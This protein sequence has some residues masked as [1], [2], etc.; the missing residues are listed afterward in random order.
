[1]LS[2]PTWNYFTG[3]SDNSGFPI[4]FLSIDW[5]IIFVEI[6]SKWNN[7]KVKDIAIFNTI[8]VII[9]LKVLFLKCCCWC[10]HS[11]FYHCDQRRHIVTHGIIYYP[12]SETKKNY[13]IID[14]FCHVYWYEGFIINLRI[15]Y[16]FVIFLV[17]ENPN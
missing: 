4:N 8:F 17:F 9:D 2:T 7:I 10:G 16:I 12:N 15:P 3:T 1:M 13:Q 11:F 5:A 6:I 14:W